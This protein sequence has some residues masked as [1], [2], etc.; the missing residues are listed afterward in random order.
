[1]ALTREEAQEHGLLFVDEGVN[2]PSDP[3]QAIFTADAT[4]E[5]HTVSFQGKSEEDILAQFESVLIARRLI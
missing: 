4:I 2:H 1:M 3:D 5:G